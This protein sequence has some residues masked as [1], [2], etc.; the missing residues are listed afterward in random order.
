MKGKKDYFE[1]KLGGAEGIAG[2][3]EVVKEVVLE[4]LGKERG[5]LMLGLA[6]LGITNEGYIGAYYPVDSNVI[7]M[8]KA[9]LR[10]VERYRPEM[11]KPYVFHILLH[12]YIHALGML[13]ERHT[14]QLAYAIS[15]EIFGEEHM[16][17]RLARNITAVLPEIMYPGSDFSMPD[18]GIELVEGFDYSSWGYIG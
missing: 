11:L 2:I 6:D 13:D 12:E 17:T 5:G 4:T 9:P 7:V 8:N 10:R 14:R 3:F 16:V 1:E 15:A 18:M